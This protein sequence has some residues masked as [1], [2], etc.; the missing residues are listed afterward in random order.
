MPEY[1]I[2]QPDS[3][4]ARG[5]FDL[6]RIQ[7]LVEA[8]QVTEETLYF[9]DAGQ[10]WRK[11]VDDPEMKAA[12]FPEKTRVTLRRKEKGD[13]KNLNQNEDQKPK[14]SVEQMLAAAEGATEETKHTKEKQKWAERAAGLAVPGLGVAMLV[15]ALI[16]IFPNLDLLQR[17]GED[18]DYLLLLREPLLLLGLFDLFIALCL[19]LAVTEIFTLLRLR[20]TA[21]MGYFGYFY[22]ALWQNGDPSGL[23][24]MASA[25]AAGIGVFFATLTQ[26]FTLMVISLTLAIGGSVAYGIFTLI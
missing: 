7:S 11:L 8:G 4:E 19:F 12:I 5:P 18:S 14:V 24:L 23:G 16:H 25:L 17:I 3:E 9:D 10:A 15:Q 13:F 22:W 21:G 26:R 1:Y 2:R 6:G 20:A